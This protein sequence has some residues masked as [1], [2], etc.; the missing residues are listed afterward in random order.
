MVRV[1]N[2]FCRDWYN[3]TA[4]VPGGQV[5]MRDVKNYIKPAADVP[6][7]FVLSFSYVFK[8][9]VVDGKRFASGVKWANAH[10]Y[11]P[12]NDYTARCCAVG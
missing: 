7:A 10:A 5:C 2:G 3:Y 8:L 6:Q 12:A 9:P 11:V 1:V 4:C